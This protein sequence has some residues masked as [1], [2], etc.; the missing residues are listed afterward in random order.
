MSDL[1]SRI[2]GRFPALAVAGDPALERFLA[3]GRQVSLPAGTPVFHSGDACRAYL[4][5][6]SGRVPVR[7]IGESGREVTLYEVQAGDSCVLTTACLLGDQPYT[8]EAV[9]AT[10]VTACLFDRAAFERA[11]DGSASLRRFVLGSLSQRLGS[12]IARFDEVAFGDIDRRIARALLATGQ[13]DVR[14]THAALATATGS[15][16]EVVSRHLKR[17]EAQGWV[18]LRR[19]CVQIADRD[20]LRRLAH[21]GPV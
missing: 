14:E 10:D 1:A 18:K 13:D 20:A 9:A 17:F 16:R 6:L 2:R 21:P 15:A 12:L 4:L 5:V 8:A 11:L 3:A 7:L 19:G